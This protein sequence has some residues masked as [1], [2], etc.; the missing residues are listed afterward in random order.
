MSDK[1]YPDVP[2]YEHES[3][4]RTSKS[5]INSLLKK[6]KEV[7]AERNSLRRECAQLRREQHNKFRDCSDTVFLAEL[8]RRL[9]K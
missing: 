6:Q 8:A 2:W 3:L 5:R 1:T 4:K 7:I 9:A